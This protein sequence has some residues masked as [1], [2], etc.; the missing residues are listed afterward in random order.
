M[1]KVYIFI[2]ALILL[3]IGECL[4]VYTFLDYG[5]RIT[6]LEERLDAMPTFALPESKGEK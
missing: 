6:A 2:A 3:T 5:W 1:I 4:R